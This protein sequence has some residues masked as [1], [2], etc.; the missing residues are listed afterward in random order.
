[1]TT[2][3]NAE[4]TMPLDP[5]EEAFRA[6][7][8][9]ICAI[10]RKKDITSRDDPR[11]RQIVDRYKDRYPSLTPELIAEEVRASYSSPIDSLYI[12]D[13]HSIASAL[14]RSTAPAPGSAWSS[15]QLGDEGRLMDITYNRHEGVKSEDLTLDD[16]SESPPAKESAGCWSAFHKM[17]RENGGYNPVTYAILLTFSLVLMFLT[18]IIFTHVNY[19]H[20]PYRDWAL[21]GGV[22]P[23]SAEFRVR[24]PSS[25]DGKRREFV[26]STSSNLAIEKY[27]ILNVPV[28]FGDFDAEEHHVRKISLKDLRPLTSYYYGITRPQRLPNSAVV[29]GDVGAFTTPAPEG[30][31]MDFTIATGSCALTGSKS[32]MFSSIL[33]LDPLMFIHMGD[34]HYLDLNTLDVDER[35]EAYDKVMGSPSQRLLYMR[36]IFSYIWDDHDWLGNNEDSD[37]KEAALVAKRAY[38]LGIP[39]YPLGS[40]STNE[41][42]A[43]KYQAFTVGTV[44]FVITDLRSESVASSEYFSGK[45]YSKEQK[46]WLFDEFSRAENYD[47]VVW[48]TTRPWTHP[49]K[50]GSDTWGGFVPDRDQLSAHIANTIGAGP[51]NLLVISGD[52]HMVA[53]DDGSSTDFSG[54]DWYPGGFP[55]LHSGP[56]ANYGGVT[57]MFKPNT[58]HFTDGCKAYSNELNN[59]FSTVD[60]YFPA[61]DDWW[62]QACLRIRSYAG[63]SSNVIFEKEMCGELM[64]HGTPEQDTCTLP[65]MPVDTLVLFITAGSLIVFNFFLI[66]MFLGLDGCNTAFSYFGIGA[67]FFL[68][69]LFAAFGGALAF[70][71]MLGGINMIVVSALLLTQSIMGSLFVGRAVFGYCTSQD[72]DKELTKCNTEDL[73]GAARS[74]EKD[75]EM[76]MKA[77]EEDGEATYEDTIDYSPSHRAMDVKESA[78]HS[79]KSEKSNSR[80]GSDISAA[81]AMSRSDSRESTGNSAATG[82]GEAATVVSEVM[83]GIEVNSDN[84]DAPEKAQATARSEGNNANSGAP[85]TGDEIIQD[86]SSFE[87]SFS[88]S[89]PSLPHLKK[90]KSVLSLKSV[91][92]R[93]RSAPDVEESPP[94]VA[95][96]QSPSLREVEIGNPSMLFEDSSL[97]DVENVPKEEEGIEVTNPTNRGTRV[98]ARVSPKLV[99]L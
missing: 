15:A 87:E 89:F 61:E 38:S 75:H 73:E 68:L 17:R 86:L 71:V 54:Q 82:S 42:D 94:E 1:M 25:D 3:M 74:L 35:L 88:F 30:T 90:V 45:V 19:N 39:H 53:F 78:D 84:S 10:C 46:R 49:A 95:I 4:E 98:R 58:E 32:D 11:L 51:R 67:S 96:R 97:P 83:D 16:G 47:F 59:Q 76:D 81:S 29:A 63:D 56:L 43:A 69:T 80:G 24:G 23:T 62:D 92:G 14:T 28:S 36:T 22:T 57:E 52:N 6:L 26:V 27:Q 2:V 77:I 64:K 79:A 70:G 9:T 34:L 21:A 66:V 33:D 18:S 48:V 7:K 65:T 41:A 85:E 93:S 72:T 60:F 55:L 31:R 37:D 13:R 8:S 5:E 99:E 12:D 50:L 40:T 91:S 20:G 44:R